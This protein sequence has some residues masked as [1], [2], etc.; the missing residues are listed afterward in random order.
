MRLC[1]F[2]AL[3]GIVLAMLGGCIPAARP[4]QEYPEVGGTLTANA[5][6]VTN[7]RPVY[8]HC[9]GSNPCGREDE[10]KETDGE[11]AFRLPGE[12]AR[13]RLPP[14][15]E[16]T[17]DPPFQWSLCLEE[18]GRRRV[19][20]KSSSTRFRWTSLSLPATL[21]KAVR[22]WNGIDECW[23][24]SSKPLQQLNGAARMSETE[25]LRCAIHS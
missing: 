14:I 12:A 3:W 25:T 23:V 19:I 9:W 17:F 1:C 7:A 6:P 8:S 5:Q 2:S 13:I 20:Y 15:W 18:A 4:W 10:V 24:P 16:G 22:S 21:M 11:G